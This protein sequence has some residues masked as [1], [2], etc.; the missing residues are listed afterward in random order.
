MD[1]TLENQVTEYPAGSPCATGNCPIPEANNVEEAEGNLVQKGD[2]IIFNL[3]G[4]VRSGKVISKGSKFL[5]IDTIGLQ[6]NTKITADTEFVP[7][8]VFVEKAVLDSL[9]AGVQA[10]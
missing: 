9:E 6:S 10:A 8:T 2:L 7:M 5:G 1:T 3:R 4:K